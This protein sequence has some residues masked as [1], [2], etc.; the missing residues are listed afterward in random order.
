LSTEY[1]QHS[2]DVNTTQVKTAFDPAASDAEGLRS[3]LK[4]LIP[5][6]LKQLQSGFGLKWL[7]V[8]NELEAEAALWSAYSSFVTHCGN[9]EFADAEGPEELAGH[10]LRIAYNRAQ[11]R[12]RRDEQMRGASR[13]GTVRDQEGQ[14]VPLDHADSAPGPDQEALKSELTAYL[15]EAIDSIKEELQGKK[16]APQIIQA[17]LEDMDQTQKAIATKLGINQA[18]VNRWLKWFHDQIRKKVEESGVA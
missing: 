3:C 14:P 2:E 12:R 7:R 8:P 13:R 1:P 16:N 4:T 6:A 5:I 10:L 9:G 17:Y 15:R 18:T 11:R